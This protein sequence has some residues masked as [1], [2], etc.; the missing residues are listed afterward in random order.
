VNPELDL[1]HPVDH[2]KASELFLVGGNGLRHLK[3]GIIFMFFFG[4]EFLVKSKISFINFCPCD[5]AQCKF[6]N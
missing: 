4:T 3:R 1:I 5:I 6:Q 2:M